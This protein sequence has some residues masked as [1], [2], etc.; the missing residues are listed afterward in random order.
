MR[1]KIADEPAGT[2]FQDYGRYTL[3]RQEPHGDRVAVAA[4]LPDVRHAQHDGP[5]PRLNVAGLVT[6]AR[7]QATDVDRL[8]S[9]A[10]PP[11]EPRR[12]AKSE[13]NHGLL[14]VSRVRKGDLEAGRPLGD[15]ERPLEQLLVVGARDIAR[16][17]YLAALKGPRYVLRGGPFRPAFVKRCSE[18]L[19]LIDRHEVDAGA[20]CRA[21]A[22]PGRR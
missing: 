4:A 9:S 18:Q 6:V 17:Q 15:V 13:I 8:R 1:M 19:V 14:A 10:A 5:S 7:S 22:L 20:D 16:Q 11:A 3:V 12:T 21:P 2:T